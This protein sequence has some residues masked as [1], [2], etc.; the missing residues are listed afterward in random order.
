MSRVSSPAGLHNEAATLA[1]RVVTIGTSNTLT[2][3]KETY[4]N[5]L[6]VLTGGAGSITLTMPHAY[7]TGDVYHFVL[8]GP[9]TSNGIQ[10]NL[11]H[12]VS[13]NAY[14]GTAFVTEAS[15]STMG[16]FSASAGLQAD[17]I[18]L[19]STTTGGQRAGDTIVLRDLEVGVWFVEDMRVTAS[20]EEATPFSAP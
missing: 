5:R 6:I 14:R 9:Q 1:E 18:T 4:A 12:G 16:T 13:S 20:G 10:I 2:L 15:G 19:N 8:D 7:G 17:R 11:S 3:D